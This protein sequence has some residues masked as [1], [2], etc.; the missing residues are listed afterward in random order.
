M[1]T[2]NANTDNDKDNNEHHNNHDLSICQRENAEGGDVVPLGGG[3]PERVRL[4][5]A[6]GWRE[7]RLGHRVPCR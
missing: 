2:I 7:L 5:R 4:R 3:G 6:G 1:H